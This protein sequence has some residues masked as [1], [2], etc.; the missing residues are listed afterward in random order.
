MQAASSNRLLSN[1]RAEASSSVAALK[2]MQ[3]L[4]SRSA[5]LQYNSSSPDYK[6]AMK[7]RHSS[8]FCISQ[9]LVDMIES[10]DTSRCQVITPDIYDMSRSVDRSHDRAAL[11]SIKRKVGFGNGYLLFRQHL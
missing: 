9:F 3:Q 8:I 10:P 6:D 11:D 4:Q 1:V 2:L 5:L 7:V